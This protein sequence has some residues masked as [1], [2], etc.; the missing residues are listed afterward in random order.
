MGQDKLFIVCNKT[1]AV[2][3]AGTLTDRAEAE[4]LLR[5]HSE[6]LQY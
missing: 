2:Q 1:D 4:A 5:E 6:M 3:P